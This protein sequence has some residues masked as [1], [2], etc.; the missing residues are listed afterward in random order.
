MD[1]IFSSIELAITAFTTHKARTFLAVLGVSIGI[2]SIII[3][4]AAG[5]GI[6]SLLD[7]QVKSFGTDVIQAEIKI[8]SSKKGVAGEAQSATVLLQGGQVTTMNQ[9]DLD[10][11]LR[12]FNII[13]GYGLFLGQERVTYQG[14]TENALIWASSASIIDIDQ[15]RVGEGRFFSDAEDK[16]LAQVVALGS[17]MKEKLF[18][19]SD[20]IGR[21]IKIRNTRF[22]VVGIMEERGSIMSFSFDDMIYMPV[23]TLQKRIMGVDYFHNIWWKVEDMEIVNETMEEIRIVMRENHDIDKPEAIRESIFDTGQ[24]DFRVITMVESLEVFDEAYSVVTLL[25]LAVVAI[26]LV[27]GGV[28]IMNVMYVIV[29]ERTPE[30]GLR[31]AVGAQY[32]DIMIQFIVESVLITLAGGI[33]GVI[34]SVLVSWGIS[35]G[36]SYAG[37]PWKFAVP[38]IAFVTAF[39]F[40]IVFGVIFGLYPARNAARMDPIEALQKNK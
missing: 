24:D 27:V 37:Y 31:K 2:S 17:G 3:I 19:E 28:G 14:E 1:K 30:I 5:E 16:S 9:E 8:P 20:A 6:R 36:A 21:T 15:T 32:S 7:D 11:T 40:S 12:L 34:V 4:F 26:S 13:D 38:V 23:R 39:F 18:G 29:K 22:E 35:L 33:V 25:L 10:D